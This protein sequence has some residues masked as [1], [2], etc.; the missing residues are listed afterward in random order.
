MKKILIVFTGGTIGSRTQGRIINV[1]RRQSH[2]LL[3][4][5]VQKY[6]ETAN[7]LPVQPLQL[8]SENTTYSTWNRLCAYLFSID[9]QAFDGVIITHGSD[10]LSYTAALVSFLLRHTPVPVMLT[11]ADRPLA[12]VKS[13]G[14]ENF[15]AAV[16]FITNA[17][18]KG[19]FFFFFDK[20]MKKAI[21]LASR[22][23]QADAYLDV[24]TPFGGAPFGYMEHGAFIPNIS[25]CNPKPEELRA[26]QKPV[27]TQPPVFITPVLMVQ[28]YPNMQYDLF[29]V[30]NTKVVLLYLYHSATACTQGEE[31]TSVL[32]FIERCRR[33]KT[34]VYGA[35]F[36]RRQASGLYATEHALLQAGVAPLFNISPEAAYTKLC[37]AY[38]QNE[39]EPERLM[40]QTLFFETL[41][42]R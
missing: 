34:A 39:T 8:L 2:A 5:Y 35:S 29:P 31:A 12:D 18:L 15:K 41:P 10:T 36:K 13:N 22:L 40:Q 16:D 28:P 3:S 4:Q 32:P 25:P 20:Q 33:Q 26:D 37:I 11:A 17:G 30:Q 7:F 38:N 21:Y 27:F 9:L 6:G 24:F 23:C 14:L 1:D 42:E 19:V